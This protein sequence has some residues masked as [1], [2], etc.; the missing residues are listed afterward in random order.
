MLCPAVINDGHHALY[1]T[2]LEKCTWRYFGLKNVL[3]M[4]PRIVSVFFA[5]FEGAAYRGIY[6]GT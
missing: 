2:P 1:K 4:L 5:L 6:V 3:Q